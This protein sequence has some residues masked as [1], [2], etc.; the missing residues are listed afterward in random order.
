MENA[1]TNAIVSAFFCSGF[2]FAGARKGIGSSL[3]AAI[4]IQLKGL[5]RTDVHPP[6]MGPHD[7]VPSPLRHIS[8]VQSHCLPVSYNIGSEQPRGTCL[9][10]PAVL[11]KY[12]H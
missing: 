2:I 1:L 7:S 9:N 12:F 11:L 4:L 3:L 6:D 10:L 5:V 8:P